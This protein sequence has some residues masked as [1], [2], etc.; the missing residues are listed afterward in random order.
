MLIAV[1]NIEILAID[2]IEILTSPNFK[3]IYLLF[4]KVPATTSHTNPTKPNHFPRGWEA[5]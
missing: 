4:K 2:N 3:T 1:D 5:K